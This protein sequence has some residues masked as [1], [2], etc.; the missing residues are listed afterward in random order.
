L[1]GRRESI[2]RTTIATGG[3]GEVKNKLDAYS[4][5]E[6]RGGRPRHSVQEKQ[7]A[8][9][10]KSRKEKLNKRRNVNGGR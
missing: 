2:F 9:R 8:T 3:C 7:T 5:E 1:G 10:E 4:G 6:E